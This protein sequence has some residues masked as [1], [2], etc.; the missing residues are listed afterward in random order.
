[1]LT[2]HHKERSEQ[3]RRL[4]TPLIA[5]WF[6]QNHM[7]HHKSSWIWLGCTHRTLVAITSSMPSNNSCSRPVSLKNK[8][9]SVDRF[10][11]VSCFN[12]CNFFC[13]GFVLSNLV[14]YRYIF[15]ICG[16]NLILLTSEIPMTQAEQVTTSICCR[17]RGH[18]KGV[19]SKYTNNAAYHWGS[20]TTPWL[21]YP[22]TVWKAALPSRHHLHRWYITWHKAD[23][24]GSLTLSHSGFY[25]YKFSVLFIPINI[26]DAPSCQGNLFKVPQQ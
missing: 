1:M 4:W 18:C 8:L 19:C 17:V 25:K 21:R 9:P 10:A 16:A 3:K 22:N 2:E 6:I 5:H 20:G 15:R 7:R 14:R 24:W 12:I 26:S 23:R 13:L 11:P